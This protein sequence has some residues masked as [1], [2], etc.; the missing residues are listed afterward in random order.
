MPYSIQVHHKYPEASSEA[1]I[2]DVLSGSD[3]PT[4]DFETLNKDPYHVFK[5]IRGIISN[6][7]IFIFVHTANFI[8]H[9][10]KLDF[11]NFFQIKTEYFKALVAS[12]QT[13][14]HYAQYYLF[15]QLWFGIG[16]LY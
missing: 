11:W 12:P 13:E 10:L 7:N 16:K 15:Q 9:K 5:F 14:H 1:G 2:S 8:F 3:W 4:T 6:M